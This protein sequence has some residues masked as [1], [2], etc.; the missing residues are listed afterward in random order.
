MTPL[1]TILLMCLVFI[2]G[3]KSGYRR[4]QI[5]VIKGIQHYERASSDSLLDFKH[6]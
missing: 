1:C 2:F 4:G 6:K 5:D 3:R